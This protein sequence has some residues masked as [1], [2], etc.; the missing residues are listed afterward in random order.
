MQE[1]W[2][3]YEALIRISSF[4]IVLVLLL[5]WE[6][7][8][9]RRPLSQPRMVR[10][11]ANIGLILWGTVLVR[12]VFPTA[13]VGIAVMVEQNGW[14]LLNYIQLPYAARVLVAFVLLDTSVYFQ[15]V[16]FHVLPLLWRFHRVHHTDLD[17]DVSTGVR[18]HPVEIL[19]SMLVK[20]M[21]IAALGAPML[22]VVIF[23][24]VLNASS[25]FTHSNIRMPALMERVIRW[26]FVTP[27]MHR[28]HHSV[29]ENE[30]N[31]N[32]GFNISLWDRLFG[33]YRHAPR[34]GQEDMVLG[35]DNFHEPRWQSLRGLLYLP[36]VSRVQGYA[37]NQRRPPGRKS[38]PD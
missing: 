25:M 26:V 38:A 36:F 10:W 11:W 4:A 27:D 15:H 21:T 29:S 34:L 20:F 32:F 17:L 22:A 18:F 19:I 9:P 7:L 37:V 13:A 5:V 35:L 2:S 30:T 33:T 6:R 16:M 3:E 8:A 14:G 31:S 24:I 12:F 28:I 23:E 1:L